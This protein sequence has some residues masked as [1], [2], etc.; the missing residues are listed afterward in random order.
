MTGLLRDLKTSIRHLLR[1]PGF[2]VTVALMLAIG[3]GATTAIFSIAE[4]VLL[5]PLPFP[6]AGRLV[7]LG[8]RLEGVGWEPGVTAPEIRDY[9]RN[10]QSFTSL[11]GYQETTLE[12]SGLHQPAVVDAA[13]ISGDAFR[14]LGVAPL[15]GRVFAQQ[16][17]D[18]HEPVAVLS[19]ALWKNRFGGNGQILGQTI[20]LDRRPYIVVGLM[21]CG[22][23]FPLKPGHLNHSGLW[24]PLSLSPS[25]LTTGIATWNFQMVGRPRPGITVEEALSD[26]GRV[27]Q[28]SMPNYP[29]YM[30]RIHIHRLAS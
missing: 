20:L 9:V 12:L 10:T 17:D 19:C 6:D 21:P 15:L 13:R 22:F 28:E 29:A 25:E 2:S 14:A 4:G 27:A 30:H 1:T 24:V 5:R 8:D 7:V 11:G 26:A 18:E 23:E 16:E 3:I